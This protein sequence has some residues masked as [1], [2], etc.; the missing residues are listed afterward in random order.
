MLLYLLV[1]V[2]RLHGVDEVERHDHSKVPDGDVL[3]QERI[4]EVV[5]SAQLLHDEQVVNLVPALGKVR[6]LP[7]VLHRCSTDRQEKYKTQA[8]VSSK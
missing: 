2:V 4:E 5:V 7:R 8:M 6:H 3:R 1:E